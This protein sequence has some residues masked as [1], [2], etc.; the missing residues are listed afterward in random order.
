VCCGTAK[1]VRL[2]FVNV[3]PQKHSPRSTDRRRRNA[4][5]GMPAEKGVAAARAPILSRGRD[6][7][8]G[9]ACRNRTADKPLTRCRKG[10]GSHG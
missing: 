8:V 4:S 5:A 9:D 2:A 3:Q 6:E 10:A 1:G 7:S